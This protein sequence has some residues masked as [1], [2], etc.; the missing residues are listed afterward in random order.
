MLSRSSQLHK[1]QVV[2]AD[3]IFEEEKES[4][5]DSSQFFDLAAQ[6]QTLEFINKTQ[7]SG[8][9]VLE[10]S[11]DCST[12]LFGDHDKLVRFYGKGSVSSDLNKDD[13]SHA[14]APSSYSN[15]TS[16]LWASRE[17]G[18]PSAVGSAAILFQQ[19]HQRQQ[20]SQF[21][22]PQVSSPSSYQSNK[23]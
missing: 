1:Y 19:Q 15:T 7:Q 23:R 21:A 9:D 16:V 13:S 5:D 6:T 22:V 14:S 18:G 3:E 11:R 8:A 17:K 12:R 4:A 2:E 10:E 20:K